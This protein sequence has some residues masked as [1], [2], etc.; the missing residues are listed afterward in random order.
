MPCED[1]TTPDI[2]PGFWGEYNEA[3]HGETYVGMITRAN[4][5]YES[6]GKR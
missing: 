6:I 2:L 1:F 3:N 5:T 4:G